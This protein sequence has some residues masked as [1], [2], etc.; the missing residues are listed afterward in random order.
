VTIAEVVQVYKGENK[1]AD[2]LDRVLAAPLSGSW[3]Q[4]ILERRNV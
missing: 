4:E 3:R 2:L 1:D